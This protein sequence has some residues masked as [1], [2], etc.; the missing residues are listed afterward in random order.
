M[1]YKEIQVDFLL[2]KITQ[3]DTLFDGN[4]TIDPYQNCEFGCLYCDSSFDKTVYIKKNAEEILEQE[5]KKLDK[6]RIIVGSVH[7]PYQKAEEKYSITRNLLKTIKK[8]GF[9][10]NILTKSNLI[11]RDIDIISEINDCIVTISAPSLN[12]TISKIFEEN[13][14]LPIDRLKTIEKLANSGI[15]TGF[16]LMPIIPYIVE[17][18]F[19]EIV[20]VAKIHNADYFLH[21]HLELKGDQKGCFFEILREFY[22]ELIQKYETLYQKSY[23]PNDMYI[24]KINAKIKHICTKNNIKNFI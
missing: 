9:S 14:S 19:E 22:P 20:N 6:G 23:M 5:L 21:K 10:C 2:N 13:V 3:K 24:S 15:K 1:Q 4:Y 8:S 7:D 11:E 12:D 18:E 16:A 17:S